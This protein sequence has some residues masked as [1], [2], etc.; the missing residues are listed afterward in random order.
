MYQATIWITYRKQS[1]HLLAETKNGLDFLC[2]S[3]S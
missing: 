3:C 2:F 1:Q